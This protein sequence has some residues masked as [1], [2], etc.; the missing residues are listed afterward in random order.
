MSNRQNYLDIIKESAA[1]YSSYRKEWFVFGFVKLIV[2]DQPP[3]NVNIQ[4]IVQELEEKIPAELVKKLD[5]IYIGEFDHL[6]KKEVEATYQGGVIHVSNEQPIE[7]EFVESII[8]EIAHCVE[9]D[10]AEQLYSDGQLKNEFV[11]KR[12]RLWSLLKSR[13]LADDA[14]LTSFMNVKYS[15]NF[16]SF[17]YKKVGYDQ[18]RT[19]TMGLF[20]SPYAATSL[21]EY[22]ANGFE[23][24]FL[25]NEK[26]YVKQISPAVYNK[27]INLL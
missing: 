22:F 4:D 18:L 24:Y 2:K 10:Y 20:L 12:R 1:D 8:H 14:S 5:T 25:N 17:L 21:R 16:D 19:Y 6:K 26:E 11:G 13:N 23:H 7:E 27:L 9:E 15:E 3:R